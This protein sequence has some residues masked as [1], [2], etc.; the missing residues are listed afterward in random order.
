MEGN[1]K[2]G[3]ITANGN[4]EIFTQKNSKL[5]WLIFVNGCKFVYV[6]VDNL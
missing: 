4:I 6:V 1:V 3:D 2:A 5:K